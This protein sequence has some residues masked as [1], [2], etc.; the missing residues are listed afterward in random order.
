MQCRRTATTVIQAWDEL[1]QVVIDAAIAQ[2][3][4]RL[5]ACVEAGGGHFEHTI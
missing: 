1:N 2:W 5:S 4:A 3:R